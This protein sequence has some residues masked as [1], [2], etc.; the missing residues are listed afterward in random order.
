MGRN[1]QTP[2]EQRNGTIAHV[3][4]QYQDELFNLINSDKLLAVHKKV[5]V[6][7][8]DPSITDRE[9]Q[10]KAKD[11]FNHCLCHNK[12]S[13]YYSTLMTYLT[14]MKVSL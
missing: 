7:L 10:Q 6:L 14:G 4:A 13:L 8:D 1:K 2:I 11:L 12:K 9:A 5:M 3:L